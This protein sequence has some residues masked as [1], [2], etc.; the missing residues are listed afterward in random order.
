MLVHETQLSE[1][2]FALFPGCQVLNPPYPPNWEWSSNTFWIWLTSHQKY[3]SVG[4]KARW[5]R[6]DSLG[7]GLR[8]STSVT[9]YQDHLRQVTYSLL[10][11]TLCFSSLWPIKWYIPQDL[12]VFT[13]CVYKVGR[14]IRHFSQRM[15]VLVKRRNK[16]EEKSIKAWIR[17]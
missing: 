17:P 12:L 2:L 10:L 8:R 14:I 7:L 11:S 5:W 3:C 1:M 15:L 13:V 6:K 9:G 4:W 16:E